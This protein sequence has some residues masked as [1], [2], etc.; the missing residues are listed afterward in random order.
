MAAQLTQGYGSLRP[1]TD[2]QGMSATPEAKTAR[3]ASVFAAIWLA[4]A[5][6]SPLIVRYAPSADDHA[7]AAWATR[8]EQPRCAAS[9]PRDAC[10]GRTLIA[11]QAWSGLRSDL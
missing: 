11:R 2:L 7:L 9:E 6:A 5:V 1:A 4:I 3:G 8:I 10:P